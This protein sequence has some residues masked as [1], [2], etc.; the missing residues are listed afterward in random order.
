[1]VGHGY[2]FIEWILFWAY[3]FWNT[4]IVPPSRTDMLSH[5]VMERKQKLDVERW[6]ILFIWRGTGRILRGSL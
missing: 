2:I 6:K 4:A 5:Y 1:M 3:M